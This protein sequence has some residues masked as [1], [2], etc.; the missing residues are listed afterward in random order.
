M[1]V[2]SRLLEL[3]EQRKGETLS[4]ERL[5]EELA[6][7]RAAVWKAV[8]SLREE[9]YTIEA[10]PNKGYMLARDSNRLSVEGMRLYLNNPQVS[11]KIYEQLNSTNQE[12]KKVAVSGEASHGS[13]VVALVQ[14]AGRGRKG[15]SFYSPKD[16]GLY[17][18]VV[19]EPEETLKESLL[20]TTAAATAVYKAVQKVCGVSLDIK[21]VNDLYRNGKKV[22]GILTEAVTDFES[23]D[24]EF[25]IVGIG[26]N[27]YVEQEK[28]PQELSGVAGGIFDT[29]QEAEGTDRNRLAAE[30]VNAL[31]E[32]TKELRLS[33]EYVEHN[34]VP[35]RKIEISDGGNTRMARALSI[36]EDG[37]LLVE[38]ED[39]TQN[40]LS[41]GEVSLRVRDLQVI[42]KIEK[43]HR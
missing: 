16:T 31:L 37:R 22:C 34:M 11:V 8:K 21:W 32:E 6:C 41:Y 4:G 13:F 1:T 35:G 38:E 14:T 43:N 2:K 39:G 30:I 7:T 42:N 28:L 19:L 33:R 23:G 40:R 36:C 18:S 26:L 20:I 9:G 29:R 25:A 27:L 10:G 17:L 12:A 15:R 24:I 3:L 5:A